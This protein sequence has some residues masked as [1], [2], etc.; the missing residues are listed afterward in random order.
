MVLPIC[1]GL[2]EVLV[3]SPSII[4]RGPHVEGSSGRQPEAN[5]SILTLQKRKQI[6]GCS[7]SPWLSWVVVTGVSDLCLCPLSRVWVG[8]MKRNT[9]SC[10]LGDAKGPICLKNTSPSDTCFF[11]L[12]LPS[13]ICVLIVIYVIIYVLSPKLLP[14]KQELT[15]K[16]WKR[17]Q[18][19]SGSGTCRVWMLLARQ[20]WMKV[21]LTFTGPRVGGGQQSVDFR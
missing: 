11:Q 2:C 17:K 12:W 6:Q 1:K 4:L 16:E 14:V 15:R 21:L 9:T 19:N 13:Y 5:S 8:A 10:D 18:V 7:Q 20:V 3:L